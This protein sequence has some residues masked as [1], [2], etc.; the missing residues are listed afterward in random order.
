MHVVADSPA[1]DVSHK[2]T[3]N[4]KLWDMLSVHLDIVLIYIHGQGL[5]TYYHRCLQRYGQLLDI[6]VYAIYASLRGA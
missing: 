6:P 5:L 4:F 3:E 1:Q 2:K